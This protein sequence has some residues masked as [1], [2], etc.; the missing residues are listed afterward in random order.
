MAKTQFPK[1]TYY[2]IQGHCHDHI[3]TDR[4]HDTF[5][6]TGDTSRGDQCLHDDKSNDHHAICDKITFCIFIHF[7]QHTVHLHFL[8][9]LLA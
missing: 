8:L 4:H 3:D 9:N 6:K 2:K 7:L 5:Q 1:D